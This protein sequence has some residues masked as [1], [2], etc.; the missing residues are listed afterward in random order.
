MS[1]AN[2]DALFRMGTWTRNH[3]YRGPLQP[4]DKGG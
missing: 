3:Y 4:N 1:E 2:L